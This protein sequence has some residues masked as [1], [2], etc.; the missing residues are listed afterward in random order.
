MAAGAVTAEEEVVH[1]RRD[2][3]GWFVWVIDPCPFH[4]R[5]VNVTEDAREGPEP[6]CDNLAVR[7]T[8]PDDGAAG[9]WSRVG[10]GEVKRVHRAPMFDLVIAV[11]V[12]VEEKRLL[13]VG[14]E[15]CSKPHVAESP[16]VVIF[17]HV[18]RD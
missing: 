17:A 4:R 5:A 2:R 12:H 13:V 11:A 3:R 15:G 16:A 10:Q 8:C 14:R 7:L 1:V 6:R 18:V 9:T